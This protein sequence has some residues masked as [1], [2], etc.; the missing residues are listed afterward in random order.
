MNTF[1]KIF[2][3]NLDKD[4]ARRSF[5]EKQYYNTNPCQHPLPPIERIPGNLVSHKDVAKKGK[6][7]H[8]VKRYSD[9]FKHDYGINTP[10]SRATLGCYLS[11]KKVY[12]EIAESA[13]GYYIVL[14]DDVILNK[15]WFKNLCNLTSRID[16]KFDIIRQMWISNCPGA[17]SRIEK[18]NLCSKY[19]S[20]WN[21]CSYSGGLHFQIVN[22]SSANK[23]LNFLN[24]ENIFDVDAVLHNP[25]LN[26]F[27]TKISGV[28]HNFDFESNIKRPWDIKKE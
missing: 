7:H 25:I 12:E 21:S 20:P 27:H 17:F 26:I 19:V 13:D 4:I 23:I 24:T 11:H 16:F 22:Q 2:Y 6:F 14:E 5:I 18:F 15:N 9:I 1:E 28:E 10:H 8:L 3:I